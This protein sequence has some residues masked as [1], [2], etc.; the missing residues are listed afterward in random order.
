[1]A[2]HHGKEAV[3]TVG[4]TAIG[5]ITGFTLDTTHDTVED[6]ELSD[7]N[8]T[9]LVGRGTFTG[10]IDMNYDEESTEQGL[11]ISGASL[12]FVFLPEGNT[13]GDESFSGTG[14]V[15]G[16]SINTPLDGAITRT[17]SFQGTGALTIGAV[18]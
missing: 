1:M 15:T 10:S 6:T 3:V 4:G 5:N 11:L 16:M 14:I 7:T 8:K 2:T 9:Y 12:A 18:A 17:V 13:S